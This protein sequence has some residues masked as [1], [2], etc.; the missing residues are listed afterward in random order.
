MKV[1]KSKFNFENE[2]GMKKTASVRE[3]GSKKFVE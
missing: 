3:K 2:K 1:D